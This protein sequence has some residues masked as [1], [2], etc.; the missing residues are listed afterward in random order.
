VEIEIAL[1]ILIVL[2]ICIVLMIFMLMGLGGQRTVCQWNL[3][4]VSSSANVDGQLQLLFGGL[5]FHSLGL[6]FGYGQNLIL[7]IVYLKSYFDLFA[8]IEVFLLPQM[9]IL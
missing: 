3:S 2:V 1:G 5:F 6:Y 9:T 8:A 4:P 7:A